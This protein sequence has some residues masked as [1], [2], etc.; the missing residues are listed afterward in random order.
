V[1]EVGGKFG[2]AGLR[3]HSDSSTNTHRIR[4]ALRSGVI[5]WLTFGDL[6]RIMHQIAEDLA[7]T[8]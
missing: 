3:R 5:E 8:A 2:T 6:R 4:D 7:K 1:T